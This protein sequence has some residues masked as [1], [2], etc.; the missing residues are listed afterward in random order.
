LPA[1]RDCRHG[2]ELCRA[3]TLLA[4]P[5][6]LSFA[7]CGA[8]YLASWLILDLLCKVLML[9]HSITDHH[10]TQ[11]SSPFNPTA[12]LAFAPAAAAVCALQPETSPYNGESYHVFELSSA[13][14]AQL[15]QQLK[16]FLAMPVV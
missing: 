1:G 6:L 8:V 12:A 4:D 3:V 7:T 13:Q 11:Q 16:K 2:W 14:H 15:R 10:T 9:V 5:P